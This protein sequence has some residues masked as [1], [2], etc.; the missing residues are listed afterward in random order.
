MT[1]AEALLAGLCL[2][3]L[4]GCSGVSSGGGQQGPPNNPSAGTLA[5]SPTSLNFGNVAVGNTSSLTGTLT[6]SSA[7]V[8]VSSADWTGSGYSVSGITFPVTIP[9]GQSAK[10]T[11]SFTPGASGS[12]PGSVKFLSNA[13][14]STLS[15]SFSGDGAQG[16]P[17]VHSVALSWNASTST[18]IGYNVYR[19]TQNGGPY[20]KLNST[21]E[22]ATAYT[23]TT[24]LSGT[25]Y[26]YVATSVDS[27]NVESVFSN[28]AVAQVPQ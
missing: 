3:V 15:Q 25:T 6:A 11:V 26:Y 24:V 13:S 21:L 27:N 1:C 17:G 23:D 28:Q 7:D 18:V 9:A 12:S 4:T 2:L 14:D 19:G 10:Y 22:P 16:Q 5:V 20:S 8:T